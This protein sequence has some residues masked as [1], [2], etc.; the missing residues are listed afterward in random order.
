MSFTRKP[1]KVSFRRK[2]TKSKSI[3]SV[4]KKVIQQ[5]AEPKFFIV[6][7]TEQVNNTNTPITKWLLNSV[8]SGITASERIGDEVMSKMV[9]IRGHVCGTYQQA[10]YHKI[11][12]VEHNA[13]SDPSID[14]LENNAGNFA[15]AAANITDIYARVNTL[16]YKV[17][18]TRTLKTGTVSNTA[19]DY[20]ASQMFEMTA[21]IPGPIKFDGPQAVIP[22][23]R[24]LRLLLFSR[25]A[26]NDTTLGEQYEITFN[27]KFYYS[28]M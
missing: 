3:T 17:L 22:Q 25:T 7:V 4:V 24:V 19:N 14:L 5:Q 27:S 8:P 15:P 23:K 1:K 21:K 11:M 12:L 20:G 18:A 26:A 10:V 6:S 2:S 9:N 13:Q 16:K 28:D